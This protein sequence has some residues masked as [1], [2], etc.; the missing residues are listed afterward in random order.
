MCPRIRPILALRDLR[1]ALRLEPIEEF[2]RRAR[3]GTARRFLICAVKNSRGPN[4]FTTDNMKFVAASSLI[5]LA[6]PHCVG[7]PSNR[8]FF[9]CCRTRPSPWLTRSRSQSGACLAGPHRAPAALALFEQSDHRADGRNGRLG[10]KVWR[11][12]VG[13]A[14]RTV[15]RKRIG[16]HAVEAEISV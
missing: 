2:R 8:S 11:R 12:R 6:N 14:D 13:R 1:D 16:C 3:A 10:C 9:L 15:E 5:R 4:P 7:D